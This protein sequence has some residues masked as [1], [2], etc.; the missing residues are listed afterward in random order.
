MEVITLVEV[1]IIMEEDTRNFRWVK[2]EMEFDHWIDDNNYLIV[3]DRIFFAPDEPT[4]W[5]F[6]TSYIRVK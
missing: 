4:G 2:S 6:T 3:G 1:F 5:K